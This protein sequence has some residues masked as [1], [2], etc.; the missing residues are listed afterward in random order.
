MMVEARGRGPVGAQGIPCRRVRAAPKVDPPAARARGQY[1]A[2]G[3]DDREL[4]GGRRFRE[5][6][7]RRWLQIGGQ[8]RDNLRG[9]P[10]PQPAERR[11]WRPAGGGEIRVRRREPPAQGDRVEIARESP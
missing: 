9:I 1:M 10:G 7:H 2:G 6:G 3:R 11:D 5:L 4:S 8:L